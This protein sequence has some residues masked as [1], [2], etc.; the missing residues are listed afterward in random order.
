MGG[1]ASPRRSGATWMDLRAIRPRFGGRRRGRGDT[2]RPHVWHESKIG[3]AA[4]HLLDAQGGPGHSG[5][6]AV[7]PGAGAGIRTAV[8]RAGDFPDGAVSRRGVRVFPGTRRPAGHLRQRAG[9]VVPITPL[10]RVVAAVVMICGLGVFGL[11][12]GILATGFAA[13]TRRDNF[14]KTW[15]SVSKV[16]FFAA[17]GPA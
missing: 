10:G 2:A 7:A 4:G 14:L 3:V 11:W 17:L 6:A 16:P 15:E 9:D 1:P 5:I 12:T 8:E 13:E